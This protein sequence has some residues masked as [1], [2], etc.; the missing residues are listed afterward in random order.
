MKLLMWGKVG[1]FTGALFIGLLGL[2]EQNASAGT[3]TGKVAKISDGDTIHVKVP[4]E[5]RPLKIRMIGIDTP[6][7]HFPAA[8]GWQSQGHWAEKA[9]ERL[10][11]LIPLNAQVTLETFGTDK[12]GR[13]LARIMRGGK[14]INLEMVRDGLA[15]PYI[16]C[17]GSDCNSTFLKR[18]EV[19]EYLDA[20]VSAK[21]RELGIFDAE[22]PLDEMPF[23]FR[24]RL[25]S[26]DPDKFVGDFR[27]STYRQPDQYK[28]IPECFRIFFLKESDTA[29]IGYTPH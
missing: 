4:S 23:E 9:Q 16:I 25:Q 5:A 14:D 10:A 2:G 19:Q 6:E 11:R 26:R 18:H 8:G 1:F 17:E 20:C 24:M 3:L 29:K 22:E 12:Y 15:L 27:D 21:R 7:L 28:R 13:T